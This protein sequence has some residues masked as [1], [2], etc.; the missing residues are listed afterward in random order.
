MMKYPSNYDAVE[1]PGSDVFVK[2]VDITDFEVHGVRNTQSLSAGT[3]G[4]DGH[5]GWV[6]ANNLAYAKAGKFDGIRTIA[7][8]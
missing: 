6:K 4:V 3:G 2:H 8:T 1:S 5:G 7:A